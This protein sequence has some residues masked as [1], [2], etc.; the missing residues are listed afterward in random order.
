MFLPPTSLNT[1]CNRKRF[2]I[3]RTS[4]WRHNSVGPF[5]GNGPYTG[6]DKYYGNIYSHLNVHVTMN[7]IKENLERNRV[8]ELCIILVC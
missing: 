1:Y 2:E 5:K 3:L 6:C 4:N 7:T 8:C